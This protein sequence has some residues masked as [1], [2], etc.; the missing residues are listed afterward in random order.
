MMDLFMNP[1]SDPAYRRH[2]GG[3]S[4]TSNGTNW[5]FADGHV[6]WHSA[7]DAGTKLLCCIDMGPPAPA[8]VEDGVWDR[9]VIRAHCAQAQ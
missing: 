9:D 6:M 2:Y 4:T 3:E 5:L 1:A 7:H 8:G